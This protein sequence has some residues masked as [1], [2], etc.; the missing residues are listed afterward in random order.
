[1][2]VTCITEMKAFHNT[3]VS[4]KRLVDTSLSGTPV[5]RSDTTVLAVRSVLIQGTL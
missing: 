1:M 4:W 3:A 5:R 2:V